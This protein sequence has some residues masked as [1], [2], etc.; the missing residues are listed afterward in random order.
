MI[1]ELLLKMKVIKETLNLTQT[2]EYG[3]SITLYNAF[4][5]F[6]IASSFIRRY[7]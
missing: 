6:E 1:Y 7:F 5:Y 4:A 3:N 2:E